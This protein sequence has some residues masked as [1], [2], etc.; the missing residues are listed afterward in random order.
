[1]TARF[2]SF[3]E[4]R[5]VII[6]AKPAE[7]TSTES[8]MVQCL[9]HTLRSLGMPIDFAVSGKPPLVHVTPGLFHSW[10]EMTAFFAWIHGGPLPFAY[11][12]RFAVIAASPDFRF[13]QLAQYARTVAAARV[14]PAQPPAQ[15]PARQPPPAPQPAAIGS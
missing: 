2:C 11:L 3:T 1:M 13:K 7:A 14:P 15:P 6:L 10:E 8:W 9:E 5:V 12:Q 4:V